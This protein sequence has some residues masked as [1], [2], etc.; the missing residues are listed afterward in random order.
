[1]H[2]DDRLATVLAQPATGERARRTQLHQLLDLLARRSVSGDAALHRAGRSRIA[3]ILGSMREAEA[4]AIVERYA[5][6]IDDPALL[7]T[8]AEAQPSVA[9]NALRRARLSADDWS[10]LIPALPVRARGFLRLRN[11]LPADATRL[12]DRL[13]VADRGLPNPGGRDEPNEEMPAPTI[14][15]SEDARTPSEIGALVERIERFNK[16]RSANAA[17]LAREPG[18]AEGHPPGPD[19][20]RRPPRPTSTIF[21]ADAAGIVRWV[22]E[23]SAQALIGLELAAIGRTAR[24]AIA[25]RQPLRGAVAVPGAGSVGGPATIDAVPRFDPRSSAY[26]G[27]AGRLL[28]RS[29]SS[30][31]GAR[32]GGADGLRQALHELRTPVGALQGYAET[33]QQQV[34]GPVPNAYRAYAATIAAD[35]ARLLAGFEELERLARLR[36]GSLDD[37]PG[38][39]DLRAVAI[40]A[41]DTLRSGSAS[42]KFR[43]SAL[44]GAMVVPLSRATLEGL[45]W[46]VLAATATMAGDKGLAAAIETDGAAVRLD[47]AL[48][49]SFDPEALFSSTA[50]ADDAAISASALGTGFALRLARAEAIAAGGGLDTRAAGLRLTLPILTGVDA[51][52]SAAEG[53][54]A[55]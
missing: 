40:D 54:R 17:N 49:P 16:A 44:D 28:F 24:Y 31:E 1:M 21:R 30:P 11:D 46:R 39:A 6:R 53:E 26:R 7:A 15:Q 20:E 41:V 47:I 48:P 32:N 33:I 29:S 12:L 2:V 3:T 43:L 14:E 38:T 9:G 25:A 27:H 10:D 4:A 23:P 35:A 8:L 36:G 55:V 18:G 5:E 50:P 13:G 34:F 45:V 42:G 19:H 37:E 22:D 52:P 51:E